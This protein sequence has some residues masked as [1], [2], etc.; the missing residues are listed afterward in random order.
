[1][2]FPRR[3][4]RLRRAGALAVAGALAGV[5][6]VGSATAS[7]SSSVDNVTATAPTACGQN[8]VFNHTGTA[9]DSLPAAAKAL[10]ANYNY[11]VATTPWSTFKGHKGP[12][13][14]GFVSVPIQNP[15]EVS[16]YD[17]IKTDFA[18]AKAKGLVTGSLQTYI[19]TNSATATP[20]QQ[21]AAIEQMVRSGVNGIFLHADDADAEA[22]AIDAA[23]KAGVP[24]VEE[25]DV[26]TTSK[27]SINIFTQNNSPTYSGTLALMKQHG[28][29]GAG[30]TVNALIVR[31]IPGFAVEQ[32]F[33]NDAIADIKAC[34]GVNVIGTVWGQWDSAVAKTQV[35]SFLA[36]HPQTINLV[37]QTA[38]GPGVIEAF[39]EAGR[40][41]PVMN[42]AG[43]AGGDL[44]Y[45]SEH[46]SEF[47]DSVGGLNGGFQMSDIGFRVMLRVLAGD[48]LK[49]RDISV[50]P[51]LATSANVAQF[52]YP[53]KPLTWLG[54]V[55]G[56]PDAMMSDSTLN[57]FFNKA[58][59]PGGI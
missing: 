1:M 30:K 35:L 28:Q 31:G 2:R 23:G 56:A 47:T 5:V 25:D 24:V 57:L 43:S 9:F 11:P 21:D 58:G 32:G 44:T 13:K 54:D 7:G 45:W 46:K 12:W 37:I 41:I 52:A 15:W 10:Y 20:E 33:Y 16:N 4:I 53:G 6:A 34:P 49:V 19:Q 38:V 39:Q 18:A 36:S 14:L 22:P 51:S 48:G 29:I 26:S 55:R 42:F 3:N 27:Y 50:L 40:P 59:T 8:I 17:Q